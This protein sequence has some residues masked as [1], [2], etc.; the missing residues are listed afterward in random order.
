MVLLNWGMSNM[1]AS[2]LPS[3]YKEK[4]YKSTTH[5]QTMNTSWKG[6]ASTDW[7]EA[8]ITTNFKRNTQIINLRKLPVTKS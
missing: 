3:Q 6:F 4:M 1:F 5:E 2:N 8:Q 7:H